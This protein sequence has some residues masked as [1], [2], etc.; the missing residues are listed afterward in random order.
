MPP[1][2]RWESLINKKVIA[3]AAGILAAV[4]L[5]ISLP[6]S[7]MWLALVGAPGDQYKKVRVEFSGVFWVLVDIGF[8]ALAAFVYFGR[9][10][11]VNFSYTAI[12]FLAYGLI[13]FFNK[14]PLASV[15]QSAIDSANKSSGG[16]GVQLAKN[17]LEDGFSRIGTYSFAA[18]LVIVGITL[19]TNRKR[20]VN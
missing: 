20:K 9:S 11:K 16:A 3:T 7:G 19:A 17:T 13:G 14:S 6:F 10:R 12:Y 15:A 8:L 5:F 2:P 18:G 1:L 4:S